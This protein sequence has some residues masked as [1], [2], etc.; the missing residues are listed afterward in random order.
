MKILLIAPASGLWRGVGRHR[1]FG[2][3]T[4]RFSLLSLLTVAA[5]T[6]AGHGVRIIDEQVDDVPFDGGWDLVGVTAMTAGAPRAYEIAAAFRHRGVPVVLGGMHPTLCSA[7]ALQHADAVVAGEAE[8]VWGRVVEDAAAG[9]LGGIYRAEEAV[10]LGALRAVPRG[11]LDAR[12]YATVFAVQATRGCPHRCSFC[13]VS[14]FSGGV[15]R[16]RPVEQVAREVAGIPSR[17]FIFVDDNLTADRDYAAALFRAIAPLGK[18]WVTQSTLAV[19][20]DAELVELAARAGCVGLFVG[21]ETFRASH[22]RAVGKEFNEAER[23]RERIA[24]LHGAG[25]GVEAGLV[26]GFDGDDAG[27]FERALEHLDEFGID[28]IQTSILTPLPGTPFFEKMRERITDGDWGHYDFHH[29]VFEP[30][31]M[32][33]GELQQ[34]HDWLVR[35]FYRPGRIVNRLARVA[36]RPRGWQVLPWAAAINSGYYGRVRRFGIRGEN[37]AGKTSSRILPISSTLDPAA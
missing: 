22:L 33:A 20:D 4:F 16:R 25:I 29:V 19:A 8:G 2:G 13:S 36:R 14:A 28:A 12:N 35:E 32:T 3:K 15:Q 17:F 7:E 23:Y 10:D 9:R 31:G 21:L 27:V 1:V 30:K 24:R 5:E 6:P 34:G 26:F 11:L 37:P 18:R